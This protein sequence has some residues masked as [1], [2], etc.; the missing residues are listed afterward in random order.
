MTRVGKVWGAAAVLAIAAAAVW[1]MSQRSEPAPSVAA[2]ARPVPV[3]A[4]TA[5]RRDVPVLLQGLGNVQAYN[6]VTV[7]PQ[8]DGQ[9]VEVAFTEGQTVRAGEVLARIDPRTY[10]AALD[11]AQAKKAQ[12][13]ALLANARNDLQRYAGLLAH[14]YSSRQQYDTTRSLVAQ[15]EAA[16]RGDQAAVDT[17]RVQL[18]YT[19]LT[20]PLDGRAGMRLVDQGNIVRAGD[21]GGLVTITQ[22]RPISVVFTLPEDTVSR[23]VKG[24]ATEPPSV[25][26]L[27][28]DG[29]EVLDRGRLTLVDNQ[30]DPGTGTIR[31][32]ATLPNQDGLLWP[33]QFVTVRVLTEIRRQA[34]SVPV[35][36]VLRGQ[37]GAYAYVIKADTTVEVRALTVGP[38]AEG[39]AVIE[40]GVAEGE[41]VVTAG[42]YRLQPGAKVEVRAPSAAARSGRAG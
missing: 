18:G 31:L 24:M 12:D 36:A 22:M 30:I 10:Q 11:Q 5:A 37:Q 34:L 13:E 35:T 21:A 4:A 8:V 25:V 1:W 28:R 38:I 2:A 41:T 19:T 32:K 39:M 42:Q 29:K 7:R 23:L 33:G 26:A 15:L 3:E 6:T 14:N 20:A 27:S 16:V 17:A 9:L 40:S